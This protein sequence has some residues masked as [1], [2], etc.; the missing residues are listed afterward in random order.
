M[1]RIVY[2]RGYVAALVVK[3]AINHIVTN[4]KRLTLVVHPCEVFARVSIGPHLIRCIYPM[5]DVTNV[6]NQVL[7]FQ[8]RVSRA[9]PP[10]D[11]ALMNQFAEFVRR[12]LP[13]MFT[14]LPPDTLKGDERDVKE[15]LE[16]TDYTISRRKQ[17]LEA[18][19]RVKVYFGIDIASLP[20]WIFKVHSFIKRECYPEYK[21]PRGI[22]SRSD[23]FKVLVGPICHKIEEQ[24]FK[25]PAFIKMVPVEERPRYISDM[26]AGTEGLPKTAT[27]YSSYE[28]CLVPQLMRAA[29]FQLYDYMVQNLGSTGQWFSAIMR[30]ALLGLNKCEFKNIVATIRG[31]RMS[32]EMVTSLGNGFTNLMVTLFINSLA[33][34]DPRTMPIIVEGDDCLYCNRRGS[35]Q[36]NDYARLGLIVK[37]ESHANSSEASFCGQLFARGTIDVICDPIK[38]LL[39]FGWSFSDQRMSRRNHRGLLKAKALSYAWQYP[40]CPVVTALA[41]HYLD[42]L[43][44]VEEV[45]GTEG[46]KIPWQQS[47]LRPIPRRP[48][49]LE[50]RLL[51]AKVFNISVESQLILEDNVKRWGLEPISD[52]FLT[53]LVS[54]RSPDILHY[55]LDAVCE[56]DSKHKPLGSSF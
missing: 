37:L 50:S 44:D 39:N 45:W 36:V 52:D 47:K 49:L 51:M 53:A 12:M 26:F 35:P 13:I 33:G 11:P 18:W 17:L 42:L 25:H 9:T 24:V 30:R 15:W 23:T 40:A 43:D 10:I 48:V 19:E 6:S 16:H 55:S 27:D 22:Y 56:I 1:P 2:T 38:V 41:Y 4:I 54:L 8:K 7:A 31:R 21:Y 5:P 20:R 32:G 46:G 3:K 28:A 34:E 29:E 14:P